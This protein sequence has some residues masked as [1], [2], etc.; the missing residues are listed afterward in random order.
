MKHAGAVSQKTH[1]Y[2]VNFLCCMYGGPELQNT[3]LFQ[4]THNDFLILLTCPGHRTLTCL[5]HD[6]VTTALPIKTHHLKSLSFIEAKHHVVY[7]I[8]KLLAVLSENYFND[9]EGLGISQQL[10]DAMKFFYKHSCSPKNKSY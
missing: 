1:I 8:K 10:L 6:A 7:F 2:T 3:T 9:Y 4:K 5:H